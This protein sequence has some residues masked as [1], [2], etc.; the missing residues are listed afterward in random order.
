MKPRDK[1]K[2][3]NIFLFEIKTIC[4]K[5]LKKR[6]CWWSLHRVSLKKSCEGSRQGEEALQGRIFPGKTYADGKAKS[7]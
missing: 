6:L 7:C 5:K 2:L 4:L 3:I 1:H